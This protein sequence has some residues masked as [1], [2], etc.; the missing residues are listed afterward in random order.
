MKI[1]LWKFF[2]LLTCFEI[3]LYTTAFKRRVSHQ[4]RTTILNADVGEPCDQFAPIRT[5]ATHEHTCVFHHNTDIMYDFG[6]ILVCMRW[7]ECSYVLQLIFS[8]SCSIWCVRIGT[9][10][11]FSLVLICT[12]YN[13]VEMIRKASTK[14]W[15]S[16]LT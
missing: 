14:S 1:F 6:V 8:A 12:E 7:K 16:I 5:L 13:R 9:D 3:Q 11:F 10:Q 2:N 4:G 15:I